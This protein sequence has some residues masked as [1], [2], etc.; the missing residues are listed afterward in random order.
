LS[1]L[2][3]VP[4]V[5]L[6]KASRGVT[7]A[8]P[9]RCSKRRILGRRGDRLHKPIALGPAGDHHRL[10]AY[11]EIRSSH[12]PCAYP[13]EAGR[14]RG[15]S[16][17]STTLHALIRTIVSPYGSA[18]DHDGGRL[19]LAGPDIVLSG[20]VVTSF[21]LLL[22]VFATNAAK[23]GALSAPKGYL[24]ILCSKDEQTFHLTWEERGGP[25]IDRRADGEGFG[26]L[27]PRSAVQS[28]LGGSISRDW[29]PEGLTIDLSLARERLER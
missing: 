22:Y 28:Q 15:R 14:G 10:R 11:A 16:E 1:Q 5:P 27:L 23:Y 19:V 8:Q 21:A 7:P 20:G 3:C 25:R 9:D 4:S 24:S 29:N 17:Q 12:G 18:A 2:L 6:L 13:D 26:T